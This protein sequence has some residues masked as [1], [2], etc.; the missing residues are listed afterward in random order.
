MEKL[1]LPKLLEMNRKMPED[2]A[3]ASCKSSVNRYR[4]HRIKRVTR[5]NADG[6]TDGFSALYSRYKLY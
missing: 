2:T 6:Q 3:L 1:K 4:D 5:K